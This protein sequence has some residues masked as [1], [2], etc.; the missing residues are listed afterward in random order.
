MK[1]SEYRSSYTPKVLSVP[2]V[3]TGSSVEQAKANFGQN[4]SNVG[5]NV[6]QQIR[7]SKIESQ[8]NQ[9]RASMMEAYDAY[10]AEMQRTPDK[11][12]Y[13]TETGETPKF[14]EMVKLIQETI[15]NKIPNGTARKTAQQDFN[16]RVSSLRTEARNFGR[17]QAVEN[18]TIL[19]QN[20]RITGTAMPDHEMSFGETKIK[21]QNSQ[22]NNKSAAENRLG[23]MY[24]PEI[25]QQVVDEDTK[26]IVSNYIMQQ[27]LNGKDIDAN[28]TIKDISSTTKP[29]DASEI[30][31]L[32]KAYEQQI[33]QIEQT[34]A[35]KRREETNKFYNESIPKLQNNLI[36]AD[37]IENSNMA[38]QDKE[39]W[40]TF[41]K[42]SYEEPTQTSATASYDKLTEVVMAYSRKTITKKE[43]I[44]R[45]MI[46]RYGN[47]TASE[48]DF[49]WAMNKLENPY[50]KHLV[51]RIEGMLSATKEQGYEGWPWGK[52]SSELQKSQE[53][54]RDILQQ[55]ITEDLFSWIDS[56]D[57]EP[58]AKEI[59][60]HLS[61]F[62]ITN[63]KLV[64]K[65]PDEMVSPYPS[66]PDAY[67]ENGT[68]YIWQN[69]NRYRIEE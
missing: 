43:A 49:K 29:Y 59:Y 50:P 23:D 65:A 64:R 53:H 10:A 33:K 22:L 63:K 42:N 26:K 8:T 37:E 3:S 32:K 68:W 55:N 67:N 11:P 60:K 25:A 2:N 27:W 30:A 38:E 41:L 15:V 61:E 57:K 16:L 19:W 34:A 39:N 52:R 46:E 35:Q 4:L 48:D 54:S 51:S 7:K 17:K 20:N 1:V 6:A 21:V 69:G 18:Q 5:Y 36:T 12:D 9:Y 28:E 62:K 45:L 47:N 66:Y 40:G 44:D 13:D 56:Q 24:I 31:E 14:D 58:S